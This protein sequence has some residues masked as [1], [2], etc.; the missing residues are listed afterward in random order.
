MAQ[1][2]LKENKTFTF[3]GTVNVVHDVRHSDGIITLT[4]IIIKLNHRDSSN[5]LNHW[6]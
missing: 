2:G 4:V 1:S 5:V 6:F 3:T